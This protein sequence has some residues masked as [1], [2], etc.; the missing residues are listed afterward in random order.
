MGPLFSLHPASHRQR[1]PHSRPRRPRRG[2]GGRL[3]LFLSLLLALFGAAYTFVNIRHQEYQVRADFRGRAETL[4]SLLAT[5][6]SESLAKED[7]TAVALAAGQVRGQPGVVHTWI[8]DNEGRVVADGLVSPRVA[9]RELHDPWNILALET[10]TRLVREDDRILEVAEPILYDGRKVGVLRLGMSGTDLQARVAVLRRHHLLYGSAFVLLGILA[11][12]ALVR[13][14]TR[15]LAALLE[16][17]RA[18]SRGDFGHRIELDTG[19]ELEELARAFNEM[20]ASLEEST[21]SR[22]QVRNILN[23]MGD[24]LLVTD[25]E[26][27]VRMANAA[28][29]WTLGWPERELVGRPL[30]EFLELPEEAEEQRQVLVEG[31]LKPRSG[32]RIPVEISRASLHEGGGTVVVAK[33]ISE[34]RQAEAV[35]QRT[36]SA[37]REAKGAAEEAAAAKSAFLANMSHEIRTPMNGVLGMTE[38]L[39]ETGLDEEQQDYA[40]TIRSSAKSLLTILNDILDYSKIDAGHMAL[41]R[42]PFDL[43]ELCEDV[44]ELLAPAAHAKGLEVVCWVSPEVPDRLLGDPTRLRQVL[45]NLLG[46]AIK[47]TQEGEVVLAARFLDQAEE[48]VRIRLEVRDTGIGI[49][50]ER[51]K[52]IFDSFTQADGSTTRRFGGTGLGLAISKRIVELM[53]GALELQSEVGRG[54]IFSAALEFEPAVTA[55]EAPEADAEERARIQDRTLLVVDDHPEAR[56]A[57]TG[58]LRSWGARTLAAGSIEEARHVLSREEDSPD[59]VLVDQFLG[60]R[61]GLAAPAALGPRFDPAPAFLLLSPAGRPPD[62]ATLRRNGFV[63]AIGKPV[64]A[65]R[66]SRA[67]LRALAEEPVDLPVAAAEPSDSSPPPRPWRGPSGPRPVAHHGP[68]ALRIL[69]AEDNV[70][71]RKVAVRMLQRM[72]HEVT[73]AVNGREAVELAS[74]GGWDLILMDVQMPEMDGLSATAAIRGLEGDLG[75]VPIVAMTANA[76]KGDRERCL[77]AGM[78][79]YLP[80]PVQLEDLGRIL[81][82]WTELNGPI[83]RP[84]TRPPSPE[85]AAS[86]PEARD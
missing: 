65:A 32:Q 53:G 54:S 12:F 81:A 2:V 9:P 29:W 34:R 39:L 48:R 18:I 60:G 68:R 46:N 4:A 59:V 25:E 11:S 78:D 67:I 27:R 61:S 49:P 80:K 47:F 14:V 44:A 72:G 22:D 10:E 6:V 40:E 74:R 3:L 55:G 7:L 33:D 66:L 21:V 38:L 77:E 24:V 69:L 56:R 83:P 50:P 62:E 75:H 36:L 31:W 15:P 8:L 19:D 41:E 35:R 70:V 16:G 13:T 86:P 37:L 64:R 82:E 17:T 28:A 23:S 71:N 73:S 85:G 30:T 57:V 51:Q 52:L 45:N 26:G 20:A 76:M 43:R 58:L 79:D 63:G 1:S 42:V 5:T 84:D